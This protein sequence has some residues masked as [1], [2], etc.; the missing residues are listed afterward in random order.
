MPSIY[1]LQNQRLD[2]ILSLNENDP[3]PRWKTYGRKHL[4]LFSQVKVNDEEERYE[5]P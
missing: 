2:I 3:V 5:T 1:F 4:T